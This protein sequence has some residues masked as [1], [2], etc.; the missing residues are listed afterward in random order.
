MG[1]G[2]AIR[3]ILVVMEPFALN[4]DSERAEGNTFKNVDSSSF[5]LRGFWESLHRAL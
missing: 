1:V 2:L 4:K 3:G 5:W